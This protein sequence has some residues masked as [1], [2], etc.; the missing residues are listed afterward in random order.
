[1]FD[2]FVEALSLA[3]RVVLCEVSAIRE[4]PIE[5]ISSAR[6][7]EKIGKKATFLPD[8]EVLNEVLCE[9]GSD[10]LIMG[11]ANLEYIKNQLLGYT[12]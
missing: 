2:E 8:T 6:L 3:D 7:A 4:N 5:G 1:M 11:A 12:E 10:V 9:R